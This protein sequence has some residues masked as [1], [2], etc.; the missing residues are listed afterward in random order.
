MH[1]AFE[2][3]IDVERMPFLRSHVMNGRAVLPVAVMV[4]WL[5]HGAMHDNPGLR[6]HGLDGLRVLK[7]VVL[8]S[9]DEPVT[10]QVFAGRAQRGESATGDERVPVELRSAAGRTL[11]ARATIVLAHALPRGDASASPMP[12]GAYSHADAVYTD[13]RLFHGP[14]LHVI[15]AVQAC[16]DAG[17]IGLARPAPPPA[18]W[19]AQPMRSQ[20]LAD[21]AALD[22]AFQLMI[23]WSFDRRGVGSL[24]TAMQ[25]YRQF[26]VFP[27]TGVRIVARVTKAAEH[28]ANADIEFL[29]DAG[30]LI[31]RIDGYECVLDASLAAAF[32]KN[33]LLE[34]VGS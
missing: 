27:Q 11:H 2:R 5:A 33:E 15:D 10:V 3:A 13:G 34:R 1:V 29:D 30:R 26:A 21:P 24:P 22:A 25:R 18:E 16:D 8:G 14:D 32:A 28:A 20:W 23:L 9:P 17:I 4:E 19:I 31:A 6:F 7:G 12:R